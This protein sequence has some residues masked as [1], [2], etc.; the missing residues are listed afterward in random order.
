M[1][2]ERWEQ[3]QALFFEAL[4]RPL[5]ERAAFLDVECAR[6][7]QLR[8]EVESLLEADDDIPK[9]LD[10]TL[11]ALAAQLPDAESLPHG[12]PAGRPIGPYQVLRELGRGGMATVYLAHDAKHKRAVAVKVMH[13]ELSAWLGAERFLREIEVTARLAHPN[14]LPLYDSGEA[15]GSLYYVMPFVDGGSLRARLAR[16]GRLAVDESVRITHQ[17]AAAL[18]HA[19][20]HDIIHRDVKPEN[21][22]L[23]E[24]SALVA[25]FG[26]AR[27]LHRAAAAETDA[28][29][30]LTQGG[31]S[32]G[33]PA[34][35]SPEQAMG[36]NDLDERSDVYSLG[37]VVFEMF[38]G[39]PPFPEM[40][41]EALARRVIDPPPSASAHRPELPV[42][43]DD[44]IAKALATAPSRRF[45]TA[46][47]LAEALTE[48][49]GDSAPGPRVKTG[50]AAHSAGGKRHLTR[51]TRWG[52]RRLAMLVAAVLAMG[53]AAVALTFDR[54]RAPNESSSLAADGKTLAVLPFENLGRPEDAYFAEGLT[55]ELRSRLSGL[56]GLRVISRTSTQQYR[57]TTKSLREIG[58]ELGADYVL[59]GSIRWERPATGGG[60]VRVTPQLVEV[61]KD[62]D[63]W[64]DRYDA[65]MGDVF[66]V[67]GEIGEQ[68]AAAMQVALQTG[69]RQTL[70]AKPTESFEAYNNFLRAEALRTTISDAATG[71]REAVTL[72]ERAISLDP[73]FALASARLAEVHSLLYGGYHDRTPERLERAKAAAETA[74]RLQ[75]DLP[76]GHLALGLYHYRRRDYDRAIAEFSTASRHLPNS[77]EVSYVRG[78]VQRRQGRYADAAASFE[79]ALE[80]DPRS[81]GKAWEIAAS[82]FMMRAYARAEQFLDRALALDPRSAVVHVDRA[83]LYL[84]WHGDIDRARRI[85]REAVPNVDPGQLMHRLRFSAPFLITPG[86]TEDAALARVSVAAFGGDTSEYLLWHT[87]WNRQRGEPG[88][89]RRYADSAR[90]V[91]E[92]GVRLHPEEAG[93]HMRLALAY[94]EL[95]RKPE[96]LRAATRAVQLLPMSEDAIDAVNLLQDRA[97]VSTLVGDEDRAVT[98]LERLLEMSSDISIPLLRVHP[99]WAT[100]RGDSRMQRLLTQSVADTGR[101]A[102][103]KIRSR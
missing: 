6:D 27:A 68:V 84:T 97:F 18:G 102:L 94:A 24:G 36:S 55:E 39:E 8:A 87:E 31:I 28:N 33:T 103:E 91:L 44:V 95:G 9:I 83:M 16:E 11:A 57:N 76:E 53:V 65:E 86:A 42:A 54:W 1:T 14:I 72:Y 5:A 88:R 7:A 25:D 15:D 93:F 90:T 67:Q 29:S 50:R 73:R 82:Y 4:E 41:A 52:R 78:L 2:P 100:L 74:L 20:R 12:D 60:R 40:N 30:R 21:I 98:D 71:W 23:L 37:C 89:A 99:M 101:G 70:A 19:H 3:V 48:A 26:I 34:Y 75:P 46:I 81:A 85:V 77:A 35:M 10:V 80:L 22:L 49:I 45:R 32:L 47:E 62:S 13:A 59:Q 58:R 63:V 56:R 38:T 51:S 79:R 43:V 64:T 17:V 66:A 96:A 92:T 61:S 69:E